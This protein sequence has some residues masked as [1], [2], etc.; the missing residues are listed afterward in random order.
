MSKTLFKSLSPLDRPHIKA[1]KSNILYFCVSELALL[2]YQM[3]H[4]GLYFSLPRAR[5]DIC[6]PVYIYDRGKP[7]H[8]HL[9]I[10]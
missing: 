1:F 5:R 2:P 10:N 3:V 6:L 8:V 9:I 4:R 7:N